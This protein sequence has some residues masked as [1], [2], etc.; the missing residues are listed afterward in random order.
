MCLTIIVI[1][2]TLDSIDVTPIR[3]H[4]WWILC[5]DD[6][7]H[8]RGQQPH[9][10][11]DCCSSSCYGRGLQV[12]RFTIGISISLLSEKYTE[13]LRMKKPLPATLLLA[14]G[15]ALLSSVF[16][17]VIKRGRRF[18]QWL[19]CEYQDTADHSFNNV[20]ILCVYTA[21]TVNVA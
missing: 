8:R 4:L 13:S 2:N 9:G 20:S 17:P 15:G 5:R 16:G 10:R 11:Y 3:S 7:S 21:V 1:K 19:M 6:G 18:L 12:I 14:L